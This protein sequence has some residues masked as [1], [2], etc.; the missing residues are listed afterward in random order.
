[1]I[2]RIVFDF[3]TR[4]KSNLKK[5]GAWKYS[6]DPT[7]RPTCL[8]IKASDRNN[9][10]F[11]DFHQIRKHFC[12]LNPNFQKW[13]I[14]SIK[15]G[16]LFTAHNAF[17]ERCIYRNC[18]VRHRGWPD[19]PDNLWRCSAAKAAA[20]VLP[21]NLE[22]AAEAMQQ[23][24]KKDKRG[25]VAVMMS[26]KPTRQWNAWKKA[27]DEIKAGKRI[28][29]KRRKLAEASEPPMFI[30]P[31]SHPDV[32][33]TLYEYC[34]ID[35]LAEEEL[36]RSL[37][38]LNKTEQELWFLN[39]R[40]NWRGLQI[41]IPTVKKIV[42]IMEAESKIKLKELDYLTMGLVT[43]PGARK[44]ILEFLA[45]DGI[46][47]PDIRAKTVDDLLQGG[48]LSPDMQKLLELRRALS[49]TSTRKYQ[50]MLDRA[51]T[52][53]RV[54][55]ILLYHGA[56]TGRDTGTGV[57]PQNFPKGLIEISKERPYA[58]VENVIDCD[59]EMLKLLYGDNLSLLFSALLRNMII[60]T[61]G[62]E[63]FV[64]DF[65]K[66]EVAVL[67]WLSDNLPGLKILKAGKDPYIYQAAAN[68]RK[69]YEEIEQ[70]VRAGA[71]WAVDARQLGK[72]QILGGGFGMGADKFQQTA[73]DMYR[74]KLTSEQSK[75]A[76]QNYRE[77]NSAVPIMWK[78][79]E[80]AATVAV[81]TKSS[82]RINKCRFHVQYGFLWITLPSGR[83]L[84]YR[85]PR[86]TWRETDWGPRKTIEFY[87]VNSKTKKWGVERTWGGTLTENIVQAVARDIMMY[88]VLRLEKAGY[89]TLL[90]VHD[91][92]ICERPIG[93]GSIDDYK[94][95]MCQLPNWA[96]EN[97]P[98]DASGW[99]AKRYRK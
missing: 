5:E 84:A 74:L 40:L 27:N 22:G 51:H 72:A 44:S 2:G 11:F 55:D 91:E 52:D 76:I 83:K 80:N 16:Y 32:F 71:M 73:F 58:A 37:P 54:R 25:Y 26:C 88:A 3:E 47:I 20:C 35:V 18:L 66:I 31:E 14:D 8:A 33:N 48:N 60:A 29:E 77:S 39:Q 56:S 21:R 10:T 92:I 65:A 75:T 46:E 90:T 70:A 78:N 6:I 41:D 49:K 38:D 79:Y 82:V 85:H 57:Q 23:R 15:A 96:D 67:W 19:I 4:S 36:D 98:I 93:E 45:L 94:N 9:V 53:G 30:T 50:A 24:T 17:F 99:C 63:L 62:Y 12:Q 86:T 61:P 34:K 64:S 97:L 87:A 95:I 7:T 59:V 13:W 69:S 43:K 81:E 42:G 89:R 28:T 68:T 1:M